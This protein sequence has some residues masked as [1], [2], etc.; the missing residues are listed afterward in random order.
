MKTRQGGDRPARILEAIEEHQLHPNRPQFCMC[1]F[2][3][4]PGVSHY[5]HLARSIAAH[6]FGTHNP[7]MDHDPG[8]AVAPPPELHRGHPD[9]IG[10]HRAL[11]EPLCQACARWLHTREG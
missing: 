3:R 10:L 7:D 5:E 4:E 2:R 11:G 8:P 1:G 9:N 6:L